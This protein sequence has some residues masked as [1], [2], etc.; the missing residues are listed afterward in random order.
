M[1]EIN[2]NELFKYF[3]KFILFV[4]V[5]TFVAFIGGM[6]YAARFKVPMYKSSSTLIVATAESDS[7]TTTT[8]ITLNQKLVE[9]YKE[10][11]KSRSILEDTIELLK[12][13]LSYEQLASNLTVSSITNT[14]VLKISVSN[15][16]PIDAQNITET[17]IEIFTKEVKELYKIENIK[18]LDQANLA[19]SPYNINLLQ[20]SI[21]F[22][23][24]GFALSAFIIFV[25]FYF[26]KSLKNIEE[27]EH[28]SGYPILGAI[29]E[30][31]VKGGIYE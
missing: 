14:D 12:L 8:D 23:M 30:L 3:K 5:V 13:D 22:A 9:T 31:K 19:I 18:I 15:V 2:L 7:G 4:I 26:D 6:I 25:R 29:P 11:I 21:M 16:S 10:I 27:I 24:I 28:L 17:I 20:D 1:E